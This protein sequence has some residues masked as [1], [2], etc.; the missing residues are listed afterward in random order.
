MVGVVLL[1]VQAIRKNAEVKK[2][3]TAEAGFE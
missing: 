2:S 3:L 1:R